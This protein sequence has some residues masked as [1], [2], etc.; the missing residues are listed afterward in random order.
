[1]FPKDPTPTIGVEFSTKNIAVKDG[2]I[3]KAQIWDTGR[4]IDNLLT[5]RA[6]KGTR[7]FVQRK[8]FW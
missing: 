4:L 5:K 1:M 7:P 6:K 8:G 2:G 3:V